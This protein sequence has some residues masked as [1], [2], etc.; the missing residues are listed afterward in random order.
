MTQIGVS[1]LLWANDDMPELGGDTPVETILD[2]ARDAGY[3]GVELGHAFPREPR[4]LRTLLESRGLSLASGWYGSRLLERSVAEEL[5]AMQPHCGLLHELGANVMVLAEVSGSVYGDRAVSLATRPVLDEPEFERLARAVAEL[6]KALAEQG[7]RVAYHH[8]LG[9]VIQTEA[10]VDRLMALTAEA[11]DAVGL[12]LDTGHMT[13]AGGDAAAVAR[14]HGQRIVHVHA[15]DVD[16]VAVE[17]ALS[18]GASFLDSVLEGAFRIPGD[19]VVDFAAVLAALNTHRY[20]GWLIVEADQDVNRFDP[21]EH[22]LRAFAYIART[23][24]H[25]GLRAA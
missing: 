10:E 23:A 11:S 19:G 7:I 24:A 13:F 22:A 4:A 20:D 18:G 2:G 21:A 15:K 16:A 9:T 25:A 3:A 6:G 1:P 17:R 12:L 5:E 8:H 14:R